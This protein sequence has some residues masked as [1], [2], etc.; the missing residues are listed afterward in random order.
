MLL[1]R[2]GPDNENTVIGHGVEHGDVIYCCAHCVRQE[3]ASALK[4]RV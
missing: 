2:G 3:G 4:D 1:N